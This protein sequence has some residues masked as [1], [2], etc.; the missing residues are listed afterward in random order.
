MR[1][2]KLAGVLALIGAILLIVSMFLGWSMLQSSASFGG[3]SESATINF[4]PGTN[5]QTMTSCS[6]SSFCPSSTTTTTAYST[7]NQ[8]ATRTVFEVTQ[9]LI[10]GGRALPNRGELNTQALDAVAGGQ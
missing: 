5:Y 6:G 10:I 1:M 8:S 7:S 9:G 2:G 4:L 3:A